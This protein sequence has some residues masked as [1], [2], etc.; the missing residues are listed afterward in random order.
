MT[1]LNKNINPEL[2]ENSESL[3]IIER[4]EWMDI[5]TESVISF[6]FTNF[7]DKSAKNI[8]YEWL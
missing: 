8:L 7:F 3:K 4:S 2:E 1:I 5:E 6:E